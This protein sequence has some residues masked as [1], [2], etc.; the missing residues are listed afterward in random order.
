[1]WLCTCK[2][3][4]ESLSTLLIKNLKGYHF[5]GHGVQNSIQEHSELMMYIRTRNA[6]CL[7]LTHILAL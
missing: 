1:M 7:L 6:N 2:K 5:F 3:I 4:S